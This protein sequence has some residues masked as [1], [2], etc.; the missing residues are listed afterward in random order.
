MSPVIQAAVRPHQR[1][2]LAPFKYAVASRWRKEIRDQL[3]D[4][5]PDFENARKKPVGPFIMRDWSG[6]WVIYCMDD[7]ALMQ[8][9]LRADEVIVEENPNREEEA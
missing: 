9:T 5:N 1:K 8:I 6:S 7:A 3:R 4:I 2:A